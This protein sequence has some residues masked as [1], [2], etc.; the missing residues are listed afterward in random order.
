MPGSLW[1][2]LLPLEEEDIAPISNL[3][4]E[5]RDLPMDLSDASLVRVAE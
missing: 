2:Q 5:Y 4:E 3:M 1:V